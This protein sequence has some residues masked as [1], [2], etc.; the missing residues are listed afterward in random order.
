MRQA[1]ADEATR[2][3]E[4]DAKVIARQYPQALTTES[5]LRYVVLRPGVDPAGPV[6]QRG[7][8]A[9]V[10]YAGRFIDGTP[11]DSSAD[12]GG[13]F[14]FPVGMGR[15]IAGWDEAVLTMRRGEKRTLIIPFWLAYGEK[16]IRGKIEPRATLIFDVEL[17]EFGEKL[18]TES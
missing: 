12:H 15:V 8:I 5:G 17:V 14:N 16:G 9:T 7:Q 6:P 13:P 3:P 2:L 18:K 1:M 11:F 10:H 4:R